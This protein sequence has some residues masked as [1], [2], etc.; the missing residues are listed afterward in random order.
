[1]SGFLLR[2]VIIAVLLVVGLFELAG[3]FIDTFGGSLLGSTFIGVVNAAIRPLLVTMSA[4]LDAVTLAGC[5]FLANI[6]A[7]LAVIMTL[8]GYQISG[9]TSLLLG[10][11]ALT[12]CSVALSKTIQDR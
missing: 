8:P 3:I 5:T 2:I 12:L 9:L 1:M 6:F 10:A 7:P 11:I 4:P